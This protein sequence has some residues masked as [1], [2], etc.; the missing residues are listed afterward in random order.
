MFSEVTCRLVFAVFQEISNFNEHSKNMDV[1]KVA[2][3]ASVGFAIAIAAFVIWGPSPKP[4]KKGIVR[5]IFNFLQLSRRKIL[6]VIIYVS[7]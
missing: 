7:F 5:N 1:E 6:Y 2:V 3:F 4:R